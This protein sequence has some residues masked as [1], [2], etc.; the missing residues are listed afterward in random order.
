MRN[1]A[2]HPDGHSG[3][4]VISDF[5]IGTDGTLHEPI[6]SRMKDGNVEYGPTPILADLTTGV[7]NLFVSGEDVFVMWAMENLLLSGVMVLGVVSEADRNPGCP[8]KYRLAEGPLSPRH[9]A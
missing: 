9:A 8:I 2:A 4:L 1:A 3:N 7:H 5:T 6:W